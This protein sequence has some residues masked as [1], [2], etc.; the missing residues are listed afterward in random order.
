MRKSKAEERANFTAKQPV[1]HGAVITGRIIESDYNYRESVD[2]VQAIISYLK[3]NPRVEIVETIR[4]PVDMR[5]ESR[6]STE[7]GVD[8]FKHGKNEISGIFT[9]KVTMKSPDHA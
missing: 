5:S 7:A 4:M 8:T 1:K 3:T 2:R 6:F 9:L